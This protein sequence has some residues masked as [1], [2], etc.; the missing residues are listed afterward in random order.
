MQYEINGKAF[1]K[2]IQFM[3]PG[4]SVVYVDPTNP[5]SAVG[6]RGATVRA[7]FIPL[8]LCVLTGLFGIV[9]ILLM[10]SPTED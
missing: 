7:L 9:L 2:T 8:L 6:Q 3:P 4:A 10:L 5:A 1:S